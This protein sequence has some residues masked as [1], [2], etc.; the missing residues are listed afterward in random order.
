MSRNPSHFDVPVDKADVSA[1]LHGLADYPE[2]NI[3]G[4]GQLLHKLAD[5]V[6]GDSTSDAWARSDIFTVFDLETTVDIDD[7]QPT[8][9]WYWK[10]IEPAR[11]VSILIPVAITWIGIWRATSAYSKLLSTQPEQAA[12]S[13]IYLWEQGFGGNTWLT[14]SR[15]AFID[16][17]I[18]LVFVVGL[19]FLIEFRENHLE[20][21]RNRQNVLKA[22]LKDGLSKAHLALAPLRYSESFRAMSGIQ[23]TTLRILKELGNERIRLSKLA[24]RRESELGSLASFVEALD[25]S[26]EDMS[27]ASRSLEKMHTSFLQEWSDL[28]TLLNVLVNSQKEF[29]QITHQISNTLQETDTHQEQLITVIQNTNLVQEDVSDAFSD[30]MNRLDTFM[31]QQSKLMIDMVQ[32]IDAHQEQLI[33]AIQDTNKA[34]EAMSDAFSDSMNRLDTFMEQQSKLMVDLE[35][36][37]LNSH[38]M[39]SSLSHVA[40]EIGNLGKKLAAAEEKLISSL[41]AE[42]ENQTKLASQVSLSSTELADA[43][44]QIHNV[45]VTLRA[46]TDD[47]MSISQAMTTFTDV[48][49]NDLKPMLR[50]NSNVAIQL[51]EAS[52]NLRSVAQEMNQAYR[53]QPQVARGNHEK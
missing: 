50:E 36:N 52:K 23:E 11:N 40:V 12:Q 6:I 16:G 27:I 25:R 22:D 43:L 5:A 26:T 13:F 31:E 10:W 51:S 53:Q 19:T 45:S 3:N 42:R 35:D 8:E 1:Q 4:T 44:N 21:K 38:S 2:L 20:E 24:E 29:L 28:R 18:L 49:Q 46:M 30:S 39:I 32:E 37:L 41:A 47:F 34:Q 48:L 14:L 17:L 7:S 9:K 15:L 33:I